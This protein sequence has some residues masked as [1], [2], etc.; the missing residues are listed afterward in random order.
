M[1]MSM[2]H[3]QYKFWIVILFVLLWF[4]SFDVQ[5]SYAKIILDNTV[6]MSINDLDE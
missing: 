4:L 1:S 2:N 5:K 3:E 6:S